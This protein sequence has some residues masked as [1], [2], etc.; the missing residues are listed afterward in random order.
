MLWKGFSTVVCLEIVHY[1]ELFFS[2]L[3]CLLKLINLNVKNFK[4]GVLAIE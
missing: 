3:G 2:M 1:F 4:S